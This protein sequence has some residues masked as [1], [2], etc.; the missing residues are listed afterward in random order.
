MM[1]TQKFVPGPVPKLADEIIK[2]SMQHHFGEK[3]TVRILGR[4][5]GYG[6]MMHLAHEC[7][8]EDLKAKGYPEEGAFTV[9]PPL[10]L[11]KNES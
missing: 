8:R 1:D 9:G 6:N 3:E 11:V 7:W 10:G 4:Q 5:I 2:F